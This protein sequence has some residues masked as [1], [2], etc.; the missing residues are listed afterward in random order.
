[1][2]SP[3]RA[4]Y[5]QPY[6]TRL[7]SRT[8]WSAW[9]LLALITCIYL[10]PGIVGHGPWK[11]DEGYSFGVIHH[12]LMTGE[13]LVPTNAGQPFMEKPPLYY[14]TAVIFAKALYPWL[15]YADGAR[16]T[17]VFYMLVTFHFVALIAKTAWR[18]DSFF[19]LRVLGTLT[20]FAGTAGMVKHAHDMFTDVSLVCG[21]V[22]AMY[23]LLR[24]ALNEQTRTPRLSAAL[25]FGLGVGIAEMSKGLFVPI[26]YAASAFWVAILVREC[27]SWSYLRMVG[28]AVL[29]ALPFLLIWPALLAHHAMPLFMEW[30]WDNNVGRFFGFSVRKLGSDNDSTVIFRALSGFAMPGT[31]LAIL[32]LLAGDWRLV[33]QPRIAIPVIFCAICIAILLAS[34]TARQLYLLPLVLPLCLL[35]SGVVERLPFWISLTWDWFSRLFFGIVTGLLWAIYLISIGPPEYHYHL[36]YLGKWLPLA[37]VT[38]M[39]PFALAGAI[40]ITLTWLACL[41]KI[42]LCGKW[43]G[44][45]SWFAGITMMWGIAFTLILPWGDYAKSY[46]YVYEDLQAELT[47]AWRQGDCM[48]SISLGETEA[49]MLLYYTGILHQPIDKTRKTDCRWVIVQH[50]FGT[51][52]PEGEWTQF[53]KGSRD[54]D[55][56]TFT[57][58]ERQLPAA[59]P[60]TVSSAATN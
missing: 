51:G 4:P 43:R 34:A 58:Y 13:Y 39:Q 16:M 45:F 1:M 35:G 8:A 28:L 5:Q 57:V 26:I 23:G 55:E 24:I 37:Y 14:W 29:V 53:W 42:R 11:Q 56:Q 3:V 60:A 22:I 38:P 27:R 44:A 12:M 2:L 50:P 30:F 41:P 46:E 6:Q 18:E 33:R 54:G 36:T 31:P 49:P 10:L 25:W 59:A 47:P 20:L 7:A 19:N 9:S 32:A 15:S 48:A 17:S 52:T 40:V 21:G